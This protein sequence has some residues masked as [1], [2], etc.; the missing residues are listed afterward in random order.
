MLISQ[1]KKFIFIANTK[2][3][4]TSIESM[5][6]KYSNIS[7][8]YPPNIKHMSYK[9]EDLSNKLIGKIKE[10]YREDYNF[11]EKYF[12]EKYKNS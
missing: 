12:I 8:L 10:H 2:A 4:S 6:S 9:L 5:L 3:A 1:N 11:I 7:L